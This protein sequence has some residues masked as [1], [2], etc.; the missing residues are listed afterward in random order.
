M[1]SLVDAVSFGVAPGLLVYFHTFR[2]S[3]DWAWVISFLFALAAVLR[4]ARFNIEQAGHA[5]S[6]FFGLPS[7]AAG[8]T[9]ATWYPF[10]QTPLFQHYL[11]GL[12]PWNRGLAVLMLGMALLMVSHVPYPI[13]PKV[14]WR[15]WRGRFGIAYSLGALAG[16]VYVPRYF[17]FLY[18]IAYLSFGLGRAA[19]YGFLDRLPERD[20]LHDDEESSGR[21]VDDARP[22]LLPFRV[23]RPRRRTGGAP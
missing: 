7:P 10:S 20:P 3:G 19:V 17:F 1:D 2:S 15:D 6:Q 8:M 22:A 14:G 18:G 11:A 13:W 5:K 23:R 21:P 4:L 12:L 16:M 9:L